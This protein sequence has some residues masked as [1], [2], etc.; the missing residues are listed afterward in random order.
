MVN[1]TGWK[2][3]SSFVKKFIRN[4]A[5]QMMT[6]RW[7]QIILNASNNEQRTYR[8]TGV[9]LFILNMFSF[10]FRLFLFGSKRELCDKI[11]FYLL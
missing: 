2:T 6:R 3:I 11:G 8:E 9:N 4:I 7:K 10:R 1:G 5:A